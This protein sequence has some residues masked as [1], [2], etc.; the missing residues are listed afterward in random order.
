MQRIGEQRCELVAA[1]LPGCAHRQVLHRDDGARDLERRQMLGAELAQRA[2]ADR[3]AIVQ[4][5]RRDDIL[6]EGSV[7][8]GKRHRY[9]HVGVAH[10]DFVDFGRRH[11]HAAAIDQ[12]GFARGEEQVPVLVEVTQISRPKPFAV[13]R[14]AVRLGVALVSGDHARAGDGDFADRS[15]GQQ[16]P[17]VAAN[18]DLRRVRE[19]DRAR[20]TT[21]WRR[22]IGG[23]QK[24]FGHSIALDHRD[25][26]RVL[27]A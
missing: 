2:A 23:D 19:A 5:D 9:A 6:A 27:H 24:R 8:D 18:G 10:Q 11:L 15:G 1:N 16:L 4:H 25:A 7:R 20:A 13:E 21:A 17:V 12:L 26:Q 14:D 22:W 3:A